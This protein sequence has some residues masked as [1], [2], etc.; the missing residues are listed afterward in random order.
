M[1]LLDGGVIVFLFILDGL[2]A[3]ALCHGFDTWTTPGIH[4]VVPVLVGTLGQF[5][6]S[7]HQKDTRVANLAG[8]PLF[9]KEARFEVAFILFTVSKSGAEMEKIIIIES[10]CLEF[11]KVK[12]FLSLANF[13]WIW[14]PF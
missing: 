6:V 14:H 4:D 10:H 3:L 9:E 13:L 1:L 7:L 12:D 2:I 8:P 5:H 11:S